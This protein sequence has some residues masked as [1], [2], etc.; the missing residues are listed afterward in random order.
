MSA[1]RI[2]SFDFG[3]ARI[4]VAISDENQILASPLQVVKNDTEASAVITEILKEYSPAFLVVGNP[5]KLSGAAGSTE[6]QV[7]EFVS[8]LQKV[9]PGEIYLVDERFTSKSSV[10]QLRES[11][12]QTFKQKGNIDQQS[13]VNILNLVLDARKNGKSFGQLA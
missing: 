4:G 9:F 6:N 12:A 10:S 5:T 11:G 13:A 7:K 8:L 3:L 2:I 1:G